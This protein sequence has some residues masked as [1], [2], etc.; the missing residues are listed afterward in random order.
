MVAV[1]TLMTLSGP[2]SAAQGECPD[3]QAWPSFAQV[4]PTARSVYLT[5]VTDSVD[6]VA[7]TA[8][9]IEVMKGA[10]PA[11]VDLRTL[12]P[13]RTVDGCPAPRGLH[14]RVGDR[15]LVAYDGRA[16]DRVG[17]I[18]AVAVVGGERDR[19]NVSGLEHLGLEEARAWDASGPD[20]RDVQTDAPSPPIAPPPSPGPDDISWSCRGEAPGFPRSVLSGP[21]GVERLPGA[22]F[23]GL[24]RALEVMRPEFELEPREERPH[25][26]PWLLASYEEELALFLVRRPGDIERYSAM[27]VVREGDEWGF[28]GYF[29]DCQPRPIVTHGL[30]S[31]EWRVDRASPPTPRSSSFRIEVMERECASGS[32]ADGRIAEPIV[33]Y[34][35]EAIIITVPVR[36]VEGAATCQGNPWTP[37]VLELDEPIGDRLLLDGGPW[38]PQQRWPVR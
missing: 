14:A 10:A 8:R 21:V 37:F 38:P 32:P 25:L 12:R 1:G 18:D 23:D 7:V 5:K 17:S 29:D 33:E 3:A 9:T 4:A 26:L 11:T 30:G 27:Y 20:L 15:L 6:G 36:R 31:S 24:R 28:G 19:R 13:G 34:A 22:V 2:V 35:E 16:P